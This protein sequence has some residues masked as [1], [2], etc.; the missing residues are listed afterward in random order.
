MRYGRWMSWGVLGLALSWNVTGQAED[1]P[2]EGAP[3]DAGVVLYDGDSGQG[4]DPAAGD[5]VTEI[6]DEAMMNSDLVAAVATAT[7]SDRA[8]KVKEF[9]AKFDKDGDGKLSEDEKV[10][11][12]ADLKAQRD[13]W[14]KKRLMKQADQDGNGQLSEDEQKAM[15]QLQAQHAEKVAAMRAQVQ[16]RFD[17]NKDGTLDDAERAGLRDSWKKRVFQMMKDRRKPGER[18]GPGRRGDR[19]G[20]GGDKSSGGEGGDEADPAGEPGEDGSGK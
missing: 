6:L 10:A 19:P 13:E 7:S 20:K 1:Q 4:L 8:A 16:A 14:T 15:D 9:F 18:R 17:T 5:A 12:K 3:A 11:A 2:A